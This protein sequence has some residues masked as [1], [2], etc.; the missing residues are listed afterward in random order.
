MLAEFFV[1]GSRRVAC[2]E[3]ENVA[4]VETRRIKPLVML[5]FYAVPDLLVPFYNLDVRPSEGI[6]VNET[7]KRIASLRTSEHATH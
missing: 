7:T 5:K 3:A 4:S 1:V 2:L 6:R